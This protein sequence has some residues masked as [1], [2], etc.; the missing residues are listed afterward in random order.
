MFYFPYIVTFTSTA[1]LGACFFFVRSK[2][3]LVSYGE[4][5]SVR[6]MAATLNKAGVPAQHFDSWTIGMRTSGEFGNAE[7]LDETF[8]LIRENLS[9]FDPTMSVSNVV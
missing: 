5:L 4:R 9:K 1:A 3:R 2:D 8:P 6:M 7:V